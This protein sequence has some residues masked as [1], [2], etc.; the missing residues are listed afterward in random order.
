MDYIVGLPPTP[1]NQTAILVFMDKLIRMVHLAPT[2]EDSTAEDATNIFLEQVYRFH[3][4]PASIISDRDARFTSHFWSA[5]HRG[6]GTNLCLSTAF[7]PQ[8]DG[9]TE[10]ANQT[11]EDILRAHCSHY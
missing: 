9:V 11:V 3:G 6:L 10:C 1:K 5:V 2:T 8:T 4:L 7:H